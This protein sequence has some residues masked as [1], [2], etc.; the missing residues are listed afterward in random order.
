MKLKI[1]EILNKVL[2]FSKLQETLVKLKITEE[3]KYLSIP[4]NTDVFVNDAFNFNTPIIKNIRPIDGIVGTT[5]TITG[6][7]LTGTSSVTVGGVAATSFTVVS[8][9]SVTAVTPAGS[10]GV[11]NVVL[12]TLGGTATSTNAFTYVGVPTIS[13]INPNTGILAGGTSFTITGTNLSNTSSVTVGGAAATS[14]TVVSATSVTAVTPSGSAGLQTIT[15]TTPGGTATASNA[16]TYTNISL[17]P[18]IISVTPTSGVA[19]GGTSFTITGT[20]LN[21][22][23]NVT[24]GGNQATNI[25]IVSP[26]SVTAV[27]PSGSAGSQTITLTTNIE[28]ATSA[29]AFTYIG[30][31]TISAISPTFGIAAGG[32]SFTITGTNLSNTSSVTVGGVAATSV[33]VVSA[34]SVTAVTPSGTDVKDVA[35]TTP[36][37]TATASSA[38]TYF[39]VPTI[40]AISPISGILAGGTSF[41]I[42]GTNLTGTSSV[43]VGGVA[44]TS[45]TVVSSTSVTAVTPSGTAGVKS[46]VLITPGGTATA[47]SA[48]TYFDV[49]TIVSINPNTGILAGGTSF[50]ITGTNL[51]GT[52]SVTVGG[53]AATSVTVVS[54]TSVTAV[55]PAGTAGVKTVVL[56]T[57]GGTATASSVFTYI[58][59]PVP[60]I[61]SMSPTSGIAA[62]GTL[63]T[64]TGTNLTGT[65]GVTIGDAAATSVTVVSSTSVTGVTPS[66][67]A[68]VKSVALTTPGGSATSSNIFTYKPNLIFY[69]GG[70][71]DYPWD[72]KY[73]NMSGSG[74]KNV[75]ALDNIG[76]KRMPFFGCSDPGWLARETPAFPSGATFYK[77]KI[78]WTSFSLP[79]QSLRGAS[80][81]NTS[82]FDYISKWEVDGIIESLKLQGITTSSNDHIYFNWT[83]D[84]RDFPLFDGMTGPS[85][86][87]HIRDLGAISGACCA[88]ISG[89]VFSNDCPDPTKCTETCKIP[90]PRAIIAESNNMS[91]A[92]TE[93]ENYRDLSKMMGKLFSANL[94][95]GTD[96]VTFFGLKHYFPNSKFGIYNWPIWGYYMADGN[97]TLAATAQQILN[98]MNIAADAFISMTETIDVIDMLM[99]SIYSTLNNPTWN[100][101]RSKQTVDFCN[102]I[103]N[104]LAA[105]GKSKKLIIP[106]TS[107]FYNT[108]STGGPYN[109][110]IYGN[111]FDQTYI[112]P[113]TILT[114]NDAK[115]EQIDPIVNAGADGATNWI[116]SHYRAIQTSGRDTTSNSTSDPQY[117]DTT[118]QSS[119]QRWPIFSG[120]GGTPGTG[121]SLPGYGSVNQWS[122]KSMLRQSVSAHLNYT[123]GVCMGITGNRWWWKE[124]PGSAQQS[125]TPA[126]WKLAG[127]LSFNHAIPKGWNKTDF[128]PGA[129]ST[130][131]TF[132]IAEAVY[133][134]S[135]QRFITVYLNKAANP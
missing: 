16:F 63:F 73:S 58:D 36:G 7:H 121:E 76:A 5:I 91:T 14:V 25:V 135:I 34:S 84:D 50:T 39:G 94:A 9:T 90:M 12:T 6:T 32:T 89:S 61:S 19:A 86:N 46:V 64:I 4:V 48:F 112:P 11:K 85:D 83:E 82:G 47:S 122:D 114:N 24:V 110:K 117:E 115:L 29:N 100:A 17:F 54:V 3:V 79:S 37:G 62:G 123:N 105:S 102:I 27:T 96:G 78:G 111:S 22:T 98:V 104:K 31:P 69:D 93:K 97:N 70:T 52:S 53:V 26:T 59:T 125:F 80:G 30:A 103:N 38:F 13:S 21:G 134:D 77:N 124:T 107:S 28:T 42:T 15:L 131:E 119:W 45:V 109:N 40:S 18:T 101:V 74:R 51:T 126:E 71:G 65:S 129:T 116:G 66:T 23:T 92:K 130:A 67:T 41:T 33:T 56:I 81:Y 55:T 68:G 8:S 2:F 35:L 127:G 75:S 132:R 1:R 20:N 106:F 49:P 95:T 133:L 120:P 128:I 87:I 10:A 88:E 108:I 60:T 113:F 43:T 118:P 44:A 72:S 99:P 57:P